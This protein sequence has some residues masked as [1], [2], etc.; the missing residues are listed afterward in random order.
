MKW[1]ILAA[2]FNL[3]HKILSN[4][5]SPAQKSNPI[6]FEAKH[7]MPNSERCKVRSVR[8]VISRATS[9]RSPVCLLQEIKKKKV[10]LVNLVV[11]HSVRQMRRVF[12]TMAN[13]QTTS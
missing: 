6:F 8:P 5:H 7:K 2:P 13:R 3:S 11:F 9:L 1:S 12:Q 10:A 4:V